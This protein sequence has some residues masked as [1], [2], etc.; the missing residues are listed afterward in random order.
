MIVIGILRSQT[1]FSRGTLEQ[2]K[3]P[4]R[5]GRLV[6]VPRSC[7]GL[8]FRGNINYKNFMRV[9][10]C[11]G[12]IVAGS[13][14]VLGIGLALPGGAF[15]AGRSVG[16]GG[17]PRPPVMHRE[18]RFSHPFNRFGFGVHDFDSQP[19]ILIQQFL[20]ATANEVREPAKNQVY[21]PPRWVDGGHGVEVLAPGY[22]TDAAKSPQ[23]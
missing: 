23:P 9:A 13:L 21:V 4:T 6:P 16:H 10:N 11:T 5:L 18:N 14:L 22:W 2:R 3:F 1:R 7:S 20:P 19:V 15:G 17:R 8:F 12:W